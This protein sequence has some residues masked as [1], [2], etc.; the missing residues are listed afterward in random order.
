MAFQ[1]GRQ[2]QWV[3]SLFPDLELNDF[4][5]LLHFIISYYLDCKCSAIA[6]VILRI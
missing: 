5:D 4:T 6:G 1:H 3:N 2:D